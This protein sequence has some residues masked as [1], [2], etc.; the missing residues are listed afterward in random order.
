MLTKTITI[1]T[2]DQIEFE[3]IVHPEDVQVRGNVM[4]SGDDKVDKRAE[5]S[6]LRQ[7]E[8]GNQWAWCRVEVKAKYKA[9]EASDFLGC[10][11]YKNQKQFEK[12]GYY[13]DMKER[14]FGEIVN[15]IIDL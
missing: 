1:P 9:F 12:D 11:S 2:I 4:A 5:D 7:L 14:A 15:T 6:V 8:N 10:C 13:Q 3:L